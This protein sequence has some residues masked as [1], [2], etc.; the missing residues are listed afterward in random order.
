MQCSYFGHIM[1]CTKTG[2][3]VREF[4][5]KST[6][7]HCLLSA[8]CACVGSRGANID[9]NTS[10]HLCCGW[11]FIGGV[12]GKKGAW[13]VA[14]WCFIGMIQTH[15]YHSYAYWSISRYG[16]LWQTVPL[17]SHVF[18]LKLTCNCVHLRL[19][20]VKNH[21]CLYHENSRFFNS[22]YLSKQ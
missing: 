7:P 15:C 13:I 12:K 11:E 20:F 3:W 2:I 4:P 18:F 8:V 10:A 5:N 19:K 1:T 14:F 6:W 9:V 17:K 16:I 21:Y 22:T